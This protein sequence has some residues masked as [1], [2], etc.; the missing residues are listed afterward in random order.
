MPTQQQYALAPL[1][2]S[3]LGGRLR[4]L[5]FEGLGAEYHAHAPGA[6]WIKVRAGDNK[7][8]LIHPGDF[9]EAKKRDPKLR[10]LP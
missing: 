10:V 5:S 1:D 4:G 8:Y 6:A 7:N 2:F 9:V 3:D